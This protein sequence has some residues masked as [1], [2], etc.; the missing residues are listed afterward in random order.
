MVTAAVFVMVFF[1]VSFML[2]NNFFSTLGLSL[3]NR[4][5]VAKEIITMANKVEYN[6]VGKGP[7]SEF[8]SFT[9]NYQYLTWWL[10]HQLSTKKERLYFEIQEDREEII[11]SKKYRQ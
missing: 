4:I 7:G 8:A 1:N 11:L 10:G 9:M 3:Q 2:K 5:Q 6:L